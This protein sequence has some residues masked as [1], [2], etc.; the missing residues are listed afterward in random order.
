[1]VAH[2]D[3]SSNR[4]RPSRSIAHNN[5]ARVG[6]HFKIHGPAD[7]ESFFKRSLRRGSKC[8]TAD[9]HR[10]Q[11]DRITKDSSSIVHCPKLLADS[12]SPHVYFENHRTLKEIGSPTTTMC[13][14]NP[15]STS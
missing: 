2:K 7:L 13:T 15:R 3:F 5:I 14:S 9:K 8:S 1:M 11:R 6:L 10:R 4:D 12:K